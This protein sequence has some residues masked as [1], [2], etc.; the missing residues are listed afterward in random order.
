MIFL[1]YIIGYLSGSL[2]TYLLVRG[3][4]ATT[5]SVPEAKPKGSPSN[6]TPKLP[7]GEG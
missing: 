5:R 6:V 2:M 4:S 7:K 3:Q 1:G